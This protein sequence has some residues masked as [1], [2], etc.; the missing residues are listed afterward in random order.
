MSRRKR[1]VDRKEAVALLSA[2]L[3]RQNLTPR[4]VIKLTVLL[5]RL[6]GWTRSK[7]GSD[8]EPDG[9]SFEKQILELERKRKAQ[10]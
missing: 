4:E 5:S 8:D 3:R 2:C 10:V 9:K 6:Q 1:L 7:Y